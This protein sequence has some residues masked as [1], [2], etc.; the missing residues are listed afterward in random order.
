MAKMES[1]ADQI[2]SKIGSC[3]AEVRKVERT[4]LIAELKADHKSP[5]SYVTMFEWD[6][7]R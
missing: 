5:I 4:K 6:K 1:D 2:T 7:S 3:L